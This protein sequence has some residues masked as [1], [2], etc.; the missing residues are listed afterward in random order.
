MENLLLVVINSF[1]VGGGDDLSET[2]CEVGLIQ[3]LDSQFF[4]ALMM[5]TVGWIVN[6]VGLVGVDMPGEL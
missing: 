2:K 1:P 6:C 3:V 4:V 5:Q